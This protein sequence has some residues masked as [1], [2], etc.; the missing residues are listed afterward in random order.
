VAR[1]V[2]T[3]IRILTSIFFVRIVPQ[4]NNY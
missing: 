1:H 3:A 2:V 4:L